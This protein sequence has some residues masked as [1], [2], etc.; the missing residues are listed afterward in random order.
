MNANSSIKIADWLRSSQQLLREVGVESARLDCLVLLSDELGRDKSW[1]LT[2]DEDEL[3]P[4][5]TAT[6]GEKL[7]RRATHEP[8]AY[9]RGHVEFYGRDFYVSPDVLVP[10]PESESII[11]LLKNTPFAILQAEDMKIIDVG[12]GSGCLAI[13]SKLE[14]PEAEVIATDISPKALDIA[15][16]NAHALGANIEFLQNNLLQANDDRQMMTGKWL[17]LANLPYV[18]EKYPVNQATTHEPALALFSGL[19][20][21]DHYRTFFAQTGAL[22][23]PPTAVITESLLSQHHSLARL[24]RIHNFVL[25]KTEGL[26]QL[27]VWDG[28]NNR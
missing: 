2:H 5:Q 15:R 16:K 10:R 4:V 9:I 24:A 27:F 23:Q 22:L 13:T 26:A 14:L 20:G 8:L 21:L 6:L 18:P 7:A 19:D 28:Q 12:T 11:N 3:T 25:E 1:V 17:A